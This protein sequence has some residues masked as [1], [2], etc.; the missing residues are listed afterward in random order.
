MNPWDMSIELTRPARSMKLWLTLQV[1][2]KGKVSGNIEH[3][4]EMARWTEEKIKNN[5]N[6]EIISHA[7]LGM[8]NFRYVL[9]GL[10]EEQ[11]DR[12]NAAISEKM[13]SDGY[14]GVFTTELKGKKVLRM[15]I[16][17]PDV[18]KEELMNTLILL[19]KYYGEAAG[20]FRKAILSENINCCHEDRFMV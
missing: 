13:L 18:T 14:A 15:C 5:E 11:T 9:E 6:I 3:G 17:H 12:L 2:G 16:L 8:I 4:I 7:K 19:E 10:T 20:E 1:M